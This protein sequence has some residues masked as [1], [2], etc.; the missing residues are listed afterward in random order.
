MIKIVHFDQ[1]GSVNYFYLILLIFLSTKLY[2]ISLPVITGL[3][4]YE[5]D[6]RG[7]T[8]PI[9]SV[10]PA[11]DEFKRALCKLYTSLIEDELEYVEKRCEEML[12]KWGKDAN[13][14][15]LI[16]R[17]YRDFFSIKSTV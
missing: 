17:A 7:F 3:V 8:W 2:G 5:N 12:K 13:K 11:I 1:G 15:L 10:P 6:S 4:R 9:P 14:R 16:K